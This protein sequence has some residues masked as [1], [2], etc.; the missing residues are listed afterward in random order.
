MQTVGGKFENGGN[1]K[2][3]EMSVDEQGR[4]KLSPASGLV[5]V[6]VLARPT[7]A[8]QLPVTPASANQELTNAATRISIYAR[9]CDMRY[10]VGTGPQTATSTTG[11]ATSHFIAS[12]E[13]LDITVPLDAPNIAA[14]AV[15]GEGTLEITELA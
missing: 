4:V 6:D 11:V 15:S 8:R 1:D 3:V 2:F 12:G 10:A 5:P 9:G 14:L 7:I 13:R